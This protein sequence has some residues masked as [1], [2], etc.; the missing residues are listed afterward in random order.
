MDR[1]RGGLHEEKGFSPP[2]SHNFGIEIHLI[3]EAHSSDFILCGI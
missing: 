1:I 3:G 2:E